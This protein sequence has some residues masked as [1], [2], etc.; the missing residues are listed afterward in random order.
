MCFLTC[1]FAAFAQDVEHETVV[2]KD[3]AKAKRLSVSKSVE[4]ADNGFITRNLGGSLGES[5]EK[6]PGL[7]LISIGSSQSK[8]VIR[9][10]SFNRI[11]VIEDNVK[12]EAQQWGSDHGL[13]IDQ[14][15]VETAEI[16]KGPSSLEYGS[17]AIGGV[18]S[19]STMKLPKK[20]SVAGGVCLTAKT[21]NGF[22][23]GSARFAARKEKFFLT[24]RL[25]AQDYADYK[26]PT[27]YVSVYSYRI[28][29]KNNALRNTA[30]NEYDFHSS[31][32]FAGQNKKLRLSLS[33]VRT[34]S[35]FF[36]NAHGLEP[37]SVNEALYDKSSRDVDEPLQNVSHFKAGL[38]FDFW[39]EICA[40]TANFGFQ[41][42]RREEKSQY[43]SHG[44]MP[45]K[46]DEAF[47]GDPEVEYLYKKDTYSGNVKLT[48]PLD[49]LTVKTG[50]NAEFQDNGIG[51]RCFMIP[52]FRSFASGVFAAADYVANANWTFQTGGRYDVGNLSVSEYYDW[53]LSEGE[54]VRRAGEME[55]FFNDFSFSAGAVWRRKKLSAKLNIGKSFRMPSAK[56][57]AANGVNYHNFSYEVGNKDL[58]SESSYQIDG[59][60]NFLSR[61]FDVTL[62][63]F[64][65]Y[66]SNYIF[67]N[68]T[69]KFDRLYGNGNQIFKYSECEVL[70][71]GGEAQLKFRAA[72]R[73]SELEFLLS[74]E[75]LK[76]RQLSGEK[77]GYTLPFSPPQSLVFET[78]FTKKPKRFL[79]EFHFGADVKA[80][81]SQNDIV[82]PEN[83]T[84]GY[85]VFAVSGG[86]TVKNVELTLRIKNV[87]NTV[88]Y[89]HTSF[90]R[91]INVPEQGRCAVINLKFNF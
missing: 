77:K 1:G 57:L 23:G 30:G 11:A 17:D 22:F 18:I 29:L 60:F 39:N 41:R 69:P 46:P 55:K 66:F 75:Y 61:L 80:A 45:R 49:N 53:F 27:D 13:E 26:V 82:P 9:G 44:F 63:P 86:L 7:S 25:T 79:K 15:A 72:L 38:D 40:L 2:V 78:V 8:P 85:C 74:G 83:P 54:Y 24:L 28:P 64:A 65:G 33:E 4:T 52:E 62:S 5:L 36:A 42:N 71:Y 91:L 47:E 34:K 14:Y 84:D 37:R 31:F 90:Y 59:E 35:G 21:A 70:R 3:D 16:V 10:L 6:I 56:E 81:A 89:C 87:F 20:H 48:F 51:G 32:G 19:L 50:L 67:L 43:V 68:P 12:H 73:K 58:K 76:S 88:Y